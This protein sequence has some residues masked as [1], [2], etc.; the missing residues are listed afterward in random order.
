VEPRHEYEDGDEDGDGDGDGDVRGGRWEVM[1]MGGGGGGGGGGWRWVFEG[2]WDGGGGGGLKGEVEMEMEI[3]GVL[4]LQYHFSQTS[5]PHF[6]SCLIFPLSPLPS[7]LSPL[8]S[9]PFPPLLFFRTSFFS[10]FLHL[11]HNF[12]ISVTHLTSLLSISLVLRVFGL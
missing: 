5:F 1:L 6:Q 8:P 7:P 2:G 3:D 12:H 11:R 10:L 9:S 4:I